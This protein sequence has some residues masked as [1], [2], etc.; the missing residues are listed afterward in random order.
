[1]FTTCFCYQLDTS[2]NR[3]LW[4]TWQRRKTSIAAQRNAAWITLAISIF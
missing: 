2:F 1:M 3:Y 4:W